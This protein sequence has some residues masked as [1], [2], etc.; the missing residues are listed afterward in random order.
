MMLLRAAL[1][2]AL[3]AAPAAAH[4]HTK[5]YDTDELIRQ[6]QVGRHMEVD[7]VAAD[8][9]CSWRTAAMAHAKELQPFLTTA[10]QKTLFDALE[11]AAT[12]DDHKGHTHGPCKKKAHTF[13]ELSWEPAVAADAPSP[14]AGEL[15]MHATSAEELVAAFAAAGAHEGP[16]LIT[17][18]P[19]KTYRLNE[20]LVLG[21]EHSHTTMK[22]STLDGAATISG[23]K[24]LEG[25][26]WEP[27]S[28]NNV[29][30]GIF[31]TMVSHVD[32][33]HALRVDG[34][35]STRARFPDADPEFDQFPKGYVTTKTEYM[36]PKFTW[37]TNETIELKGAYPQVNSTPG[38]WSDK[39]Y[40]KD[41]FA[42]AYRIGHGGGCSYLTPPHSY[43]CQPEGR[44]AGDT[45]GTPPLSKP[46]AW[47]QLPPGLPRCSCSERQ[48]SAAAATAAAAAAT[49]ADWLTLTG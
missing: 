5:P 39:S 21:P 30:K 34:L 40:G 42:G 48:P 47:L 1:T 43:W 45:C 17:L 41:Y 28:L 19:G 36:P 23:S 12:G 26:A 11:L 9:E 15:A 4:Y 31:K 18:E 46:A 3:A 13:E 20:T 8:F 38:E 2:L 33:M 22:P 29:S 14:R 35:R 44:V 27:V 10:Q 16:A 25:L 37:G 49:L 32:Q 24:L 6:L 7:G